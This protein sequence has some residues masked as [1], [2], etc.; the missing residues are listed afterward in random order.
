MVARRFR[1]R[2]SKS[3]ILSIALVATLLKA[4]WLVE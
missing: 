4:A 3:A 2:D 1:I